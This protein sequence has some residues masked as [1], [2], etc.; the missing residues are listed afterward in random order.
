LDDQARVVV[1]YQ[2]PASYYLDG[3]H[4]IYIPREWQDLYP[5]HSHEGGTLDA[6]SGQPLLDTPEELAA[7]TATAGDVWLIRGTD[8]QRPELPDPEAV[9]G[10]RLREAARGFLSRDGRIEVLHL[11]LSQ[12]SADR[13]SDTSRPHE[14][15]R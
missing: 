12:Q 7:Y 6:W 14:G 2:Y 9:W 11:T 10:P 1:E 5:L 4:A 3:P 8:R 15:G 13:S